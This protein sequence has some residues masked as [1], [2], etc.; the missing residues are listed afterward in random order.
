MFDKNIMTFNPGWTHD[1]QTLPDFTDV[2]ELQR[3][4]KSRGLTMTTEADDAADD[5]TDGPAHFT[6]VDP[7]GTTIL[8][9]QRV[10]RPKR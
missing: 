3:T 9:D 5:A 1:K 4:L 6:L 8:A 7:D 10:P 2:R